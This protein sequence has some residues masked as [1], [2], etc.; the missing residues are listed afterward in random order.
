MPADR[1]YVSFLLL[2]HGLWHRRRG[3]DGLRRTI[4]QLQGVKMP[5]SDLE[6]SILAA[7]LHGYSPAQLDHLIASREIVWQG[8]RP[9]GEHDGVLSLFF[10][11]DF[12]LLGRISA[13]VPGEREGRIRSLLAN[14]ELEFEEL[15]D[16]LGGFPGEILKSLWR[17]AWNGEATASSLDALR[18]RQSS[19]ASRYHRRPRPRYAARRRT[20]P[21]A[22]GRWS[23]LSGPRAGF[24]PEAE[25]RLAVASQL[26]DRYGIVSRDSL[27][28]EAVGFDDLLPLFE[29]LEAEGRAQR[30]RLMPSGGPAQFAA[31]GAEAVWR[32]SEAHSDAGM[33]S[34]CDPANPFG[35]LVPWPV[36]TGDLRPARTAGARVLI[37]D[38]ALVAYLSRR[39]RR[40]HTPRDL[41]DP[42]PPILL[43]KRSA[44]VDPLFLESVNGE[45][46]YATPWHRHLVAAGFSPSRR[47]Y[48]FKP[49]P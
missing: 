48:L 11:R 33:L 16:R 2:W 23:L 26:L 13:F 10:R 41:V 4:A 25:R 30:I 12:P 6:R 19:V 49:V 9:A 37:Q 24:A 38:G 8:G 43:L 36:M 44:G 3:L 35:V 32:R 31:P 22:A 28:A 42:G 46:P 17:L 47:G 45:A 39:G 20:L 7:R 18:A 27:A 1:R 5:V 29:R 14:G 21:G 15:R 34:A 40:I